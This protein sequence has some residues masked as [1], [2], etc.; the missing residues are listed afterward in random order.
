[1]IHIIT[2]TTACLPIDLASEYHIPIIP[3]IINFGTESYQEGVDIDF[4]TFLGKLTAARELPKTAAPPPELF[5]EKFRELVPTGFPILC[6]H[7]SSDVSGTIRS[8]TIAAQEF[9]DADIRIIDTRTVAS[10]LG[11][12]VTLSAQWNQAGLDVDQICNRLFALIPKSRTYFIV[13]SLDYLV[14]GGRIGGASALIGSI[15]QIKPIL[16]FQEGHVDQFERERTRKRA[17]LRLKELVSQQI[18][19]SG[20]GYPA[21]LHADAQQEAD[22]LALEIGKELNVQHMPIFNMPPAIVTHAGPK[23]IGVSFF[24]P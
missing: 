17:I 24:T 7:P 2:D 14:K 1:M 15:L 11:I 16:T 10:A 21:V 8:V 12:L 9:P 22:Q 18:D 20:A 5:A 19:Q 4:D 23:T 3:Q 6:I 13:E